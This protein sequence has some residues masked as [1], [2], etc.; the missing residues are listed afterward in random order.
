MKQSFDVSATTPTALVD[1]LSYYASEIVM[2]DPRSALYA[3]SIFR[4]AAEVETLLITKTGEVRGVVTTWADEL[5]PLIE[6][7]FGRSLEGEELGAL[8]EY[9]PTVLSGIYGRTRVVSADE[10]FGPCVALDL[11]AESSI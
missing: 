3:R 5:Q 1:S 11:A 10:I 7:V 4:R 9:S 2:R 6:T 8:Q